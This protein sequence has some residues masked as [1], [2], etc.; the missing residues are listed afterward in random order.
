M[1]V[2]EFAVIGLGRFGSSVART[3][4]SLGHSVLGVD[5]DAG[6]VQAL[7]G[8]LTHVVEADAASE[9]VL[10]ALGLRNMDTV[11]VAIS[12]DIESSI[13]ITLMLKE[14]G[15][16]RV[17]AKAAT[18]LHGKV[19]ARVGADRVIFPER[20]MGVR[21]AHS[22]V[23]ERVLDLYAGTGA[24]AI[25]ALSRGAA[26]AVLVERNPAACAVIRENLARTRLASRARV[27][28]GDVERVLPRLDGPFDV[29]FLDPPYADERVDA[30]LAALGAHGVINEQSVVVYEHSKR[31]QPPETCGPLTRYLTRCHG[32]T[33]V[34]IYH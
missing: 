16:P 8:E 28:Q 10:R 3:L 34:T 11:V 9:E 7:A 6:R 17:V 20:D 12:S 19:L 26:E 1:S 30:V 25:E 29:V 14:L 31:R 15:V 33:C 21:V 13:L 4:A 27:V 22:L 5:R 2:R 32:D 18:E 23:T 24:L